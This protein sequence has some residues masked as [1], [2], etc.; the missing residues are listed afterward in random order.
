V[1]GSSARGVLRS[2]ALAALVT[3]MVAVALA[4]PMIATSAGMNQDWPN[5]LWYLWQQSL[6]IKRD[7]VP[8]LFVTQG[9]RIFYPFYAFYGGTLYALGGLGSLLLGNAP[10]KA[11][12]L[13]YIAGLLSAMGGFYWMSRMVG[14]GRWFA[15]VPGFVFVTAAY[16][17]T[18]MYAR[19]AWPE[20]IAVCSIPLVVAAAIAVLRADRLRPA[21]AVALALATIILFGSHNITMLWGSTYLVLVAATLF[22]CVPAARAIVTRGGLIRLVGVMAPSIMVNAW[23]LLPALAY[24]S[25]TFAGQGNPE[26]L[27]STSILV[28]VERLFTFSRASA[29][30]NIPGETY[31]PDF[32]LSLPLLPIAWTLLVPLANVRRA[33]GNAF[34]RVTMVLIG[35]GLVFGIVMT[36]AGLIEAL[37]GPYEFVQFQYRLLSYVLLSLCAAMMT[38]LAY[39]AHTEAVGGKIFKLALVPALIVAAIGAAGQVAAYP[40]T[41]PDRNVVFSP[42][43]QPP[44]TMYSLNDYYD[45][46]L[47]LV[48]TPPL[49]LFF[50]PAAVRQDRIALPYQS[51]LDGQAVQTN[52]LAAPYLV[53]VKG[54]SVIG[55]IANGA[56]ALRLP[57]R[58]RSSRVV[59]LSR[60]SRLP[61]IAGS[62]ISVVGVAGLLSI[63]LWTLVGEVRSRGWL[64]LRRLQSSR[65]QSTY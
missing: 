35:W 61:I 33:A 22:V 40:R 19:G 38:I 2:P 4:W 6:N 30:S 14:I 43:Q 47:P 11:Y 3:T 48:P 21:H 12:V 24:A 13:S 64:R 28:D 5:H 50:P 45:V 27:R 1:I 56:I 18:D 34:M 23:F 7:G 42:A 63:L 10:V 8:S 32:A 52:L 55:R 15:H 20:F 17:L 37:P 39:L 9:A 51:S 53:S 26:L 25:R 31:A 54:A 62:V 65:Y 58:P 46:S 29:V 49:T 60:S 44:S 36:H 16:V 57:S 41:I 59:T